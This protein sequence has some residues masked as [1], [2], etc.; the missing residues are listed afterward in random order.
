[1]KIELYS[2][3]AY[4]FVEVYTATYKDGCVYHTQPTGLYIKAE[5]ACDLPKGYVTGAV[6]T[7]LLKQNVIE[8]DVV[9]VS[10]F[11]KEA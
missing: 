6:S 4:K 3:Y 5:Q 9:D 10:H 2:F 11:K 8:L 1:M 7:E